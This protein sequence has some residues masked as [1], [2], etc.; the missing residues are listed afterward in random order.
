MRKI[1]QFLLTTAQPTQSGGHSHSVLFKLLCLLCFLCYG[2]VA[3]AA[4]VVKSNYD[5]NNMGILYDLYNDNTAI[6][7]GGTKTGKLTIFE[8]VPYN[9][10]TYKITKIADNAFSGKKGI[11]SVEIGDEVITIGANAFK[12]CTGITEVTYWK[13]TGNLKT[14][15]EGA[16]RGCTS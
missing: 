11:T 9:S 14:I 4:N 10:Q 15:G 16:F 6:V 8:D 7:V 2:L 13:H 1:K 12:G 3:E 5:Y